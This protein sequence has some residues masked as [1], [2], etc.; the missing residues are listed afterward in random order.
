MKLDRETAAFPARTNR[1]EKLARTF[2]NV[3]QRIRA[4]HSTHLGYPYN[5]SVSPE[6]PD[7][8]QQYL[9]NNLGDPYAGSHYGSDVCEQER[10]AMAWLMRLWGC[11]DLNQFWGSIGASGTEGNLWGIYL[12]REMLPDAVLLHSADAHYSL[13][14]A[15]RILRVP[16]VQVASLPNGE[17][18]LLDFATQLH[19][20]AGRPVI[21]ALTCGTTMKGAHDNIAGALLA[22]QK[23]GYD[24]DARYVHIDGALNAMVLPFLQ[25]VPHDIQPSFEKDIDSL[26]ISGHKMIGTPMP[27]GALN[28][29]VLPFLQDV[30][31][32]IQPSFEKDIDSLSISGHKMIG[33]P[34]PCGA[35][36]ARKDHIARIMRAV[37]Y[38]R[39]HDTTLMGSR[40][41]HAVL[42]VWA[43]LFGHGY[44]RFAFDAL[45]CVQRARRLADDLANLGVPVLCNPFSLTVVF[46]E[47][48]DS[49]VR[50]YQ[51]ACKN[52]QAHAIVMPSVTD[53][54]LA[55]F[56]ADYTAFA[57]VRG[58]PI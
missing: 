5:L 14:K 8:L 33:T 3:E 16:T 32:D 49:I 44:G 51:L 20:L 34:M 11:L 45:H 35:L 54:L 39:S 38:L 13:P 28:A 55:Q 43:R 46:P 29:M 36:V 57:G 22:L 9:I 2:A 19:T 58:R 27:C 17:M 56:L 1:E 48:S 7:T 37:A 52:G 23:A 15:A 24:R 26:S 53:A 30:P 31:H 41:G 47:P 18:D 12:G 42:A 40:N 6:V 25:D 10:E 50:R 4:A 21:A